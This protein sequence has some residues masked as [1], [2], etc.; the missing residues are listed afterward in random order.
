MN[1]AHAVIVG[2]MTETPTLRY[3]TSGIAVTEFGVAVNRRRNNGEADEEVS[4]FSV[5]AWGKTAEL[6][7]Q[8]TDKGD[9]L[10]VGGRLK[11][12]RWQSR[13]GTTRSR[14]VIVAEQVQFGAKKRIEKQDVP[15]REPIDANDTEE[16]RRWAQERFA[17]S[18]TPSPAPPPQ[19]DEVPF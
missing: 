5:Q 2:R 8:Y 3:T 18:G 9:E 1:Y 6:V 17:S 15:P 14:V 19:N 7:T 12:E 16:H 10:L 4:F 11:Q 13:D